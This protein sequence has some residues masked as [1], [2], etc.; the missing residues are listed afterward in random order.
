MRTLKKELNCY[1]WTGSNFEELKKVFGHLV[2]IG[3]DSDGNSFLKIR[4]INYSAGFQRV[5]K[6][7]YLY[8]DATGDMCAATEEKLKKQGWR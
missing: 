2:S 6:N 8:L 1:L 4:K 7:S 3:F 5:S